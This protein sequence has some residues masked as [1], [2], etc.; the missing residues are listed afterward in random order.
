MAFEGAPFKLSQEYID[1]MGGT[2]SE[3]F[4]SFKS[5]FKQGFLVLRKYTDNFE[6][7]LKI[8]YCGTFFLFSFLSFSFL[9]LF[10]SFFPFDK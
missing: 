2:E 5:L 1:L 7:L 8:M 3:H 4:K 10:F 6:L 9:F